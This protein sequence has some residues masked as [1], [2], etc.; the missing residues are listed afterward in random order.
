MSKAFPGLNLD[1]KLYWE[2]LNDLDGEYYLKAVMITIRDTK[3]LYPGSN[4]IA[5][6]RSLA[7]DMQ[8]EYR[9]NNSL[10]IEAETEKERI[11]RWQKES[12]PMPEECREALFK[13]GIKV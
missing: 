10:K 5:I 2:I 12:V 3:E 6:I 4:L 7:V 1:P 11:D 9:V 13:M 8:G